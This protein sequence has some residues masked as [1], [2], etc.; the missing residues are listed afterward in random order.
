MIT[1][2]P[3]SVS[4]SASRTIC[5]YTSRRHQLAWWTFFFTSPR[6]IPMPKSMSGATD[7]AVTL[8]FSSRST[9]PKWTL[10]TLK[11]HPA[12]ENIPRRESVS[13]GKNSHFCAKPNKARRRN[14]AGITRRNTNEKWVC[15]S[16]AHK[17]IPSIHDVVTDFHH[18]QICSLFVKKQ[19]LCLVDL[20]KN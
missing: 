11:L 19:L 17:W 3:H 20:K 7:G 10:Q 15:A 1:A 16:S 2:V 5:T 4:T 18:I 8:S 14:A 6:T 13:I 9:V 12:L